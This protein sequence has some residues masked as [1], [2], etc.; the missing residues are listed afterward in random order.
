MKERKKPFKTKLTEE[1]LEKVNAGTSMPWNWN[2]DMTRWSD[3]GD[4]PKF[5]VGDQVVTDNVVYGV[6]KKVL[7][8]E[9]AS[10][11]FGGKQFR[12]EVFF[13]YN[14]FYMKENDVT[15]IHFEHELALVK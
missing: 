9:K 7:S 2:W 11:L 15:V 14:P 1:E 6:I 8:K 12:Y 3:S 13:K 4:T 10:V 5:K